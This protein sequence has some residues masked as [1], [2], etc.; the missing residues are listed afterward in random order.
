MDNLL[1]TRKWKGQSNFPLERFIQQHRNAYV[2]MHACTQHVNY[3]LPNEHSRV[4]YVLDD[5][6]NTHPPLLATMA[7]I[8]E[9]IGTD[10]APG[11]CDNFENSDAYLLPKD[12]VIK[13]RS[14]S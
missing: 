4:G 7:N 6:E 2:S 1:N 3:Q 13:R 14:E 11:K 10:A 8:E 9:D 5:I 12:P